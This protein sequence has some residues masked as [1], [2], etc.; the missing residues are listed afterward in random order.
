MLGSS[1]VILCSYIMCVY[2]FL[3]G[4]WEGKGGLGGAQYRALRATDRMVLR[5]VGVGCFFVYMG[6]GVPF[7]LFLFCF[8]QKI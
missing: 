5:G 2:L 7:F 8:N 6:G 1:G 3:L 4:K